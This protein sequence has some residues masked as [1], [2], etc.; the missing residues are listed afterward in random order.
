MKNYTPCLGSMQVAGKILCF[1]DPAYLI[2]NAAAEDEQFEL[3]KMI[4]VESGFAEARAQLKSMLFVIES[5]IMLRGSAFS[6]E[7]LREMSRYA[8][9]ARATIE[10][11]DK[12]AEE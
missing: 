5:I 4:E 2:A 1:E 8:E 3:A 12:T 9:S 10:K 7:A 6:P 11:L